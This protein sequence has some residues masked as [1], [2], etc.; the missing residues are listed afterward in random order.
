[1]KHQRRP[2]IWLIPILAVAFVCPSFSNASEI[3]SVSLKD[4]PT[5]QNE[6][7]VRFK[8]TLSAANVY[9]VPKV[10]IGWTLNITNSLNEQPPWNTIL[11]AS[12]GIGNAALYQPFFKHFVIIEKYIGNWA[13]NLKFDIEVKLTMTA[14]F[15]KYSEKI[16]K[17]N[18]VIL[19]RI[20]NE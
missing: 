16:F 6:R 15:E 20:K 3:Y 7:I 12:I 14:D 13:E 19:D 2:I 17:M 11:D 18:D 4:F 1:M 9:S 8:V 5:A 10:P